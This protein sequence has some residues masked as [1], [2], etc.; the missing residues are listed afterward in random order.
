MFFDVVFNGFEGTPLEKILADQQTYCRS[1]TSQ[2]SKCVSLASLLIAIST[3]SSSFAKSNK[4]AERWAGPIP[5]CS[6]RCI[7]MI[8]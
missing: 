8:F 3:S 7:L 4:G 2:T 6:S 5:C 1:T